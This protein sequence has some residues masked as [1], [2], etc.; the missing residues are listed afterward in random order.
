MSLERDIDN[1]AYGYCGMTAF[2]LWS[3]DRDKYK[4]LSNTQMLS[5]GS[6]LPRG[7]SRTIVK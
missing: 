2:T 5:I 3:K 4:D 1:S 6:N 7:R